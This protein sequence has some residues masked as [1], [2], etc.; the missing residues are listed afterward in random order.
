MLTNCMELAQLAVLQ[1]VD[2]YALVD[3]RGHAPYYYVTRSNHCVIE[4]V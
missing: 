2:R 4:M 3:S 1:I